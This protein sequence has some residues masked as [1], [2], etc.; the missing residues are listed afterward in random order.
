MPASRLIMIR[1]LTTLFWLL[2]IALTATPMVRAQGPLV[3][4]ATSGRWSEPSTWEN[5]RLPGAG[6]RV[7]VRSG[8]SVV[9]DARVESAIRSIHVA[10]TLDFD[11]DRDV[12]LTVGLIK[13]QSG[14]DTSETGLD[15]HEGMVEAG[16]G[17]GMERPALLVGTARRPISAGHTAV[18]RL[19][20]VNGLDPENCPAIVCQ[21]GRMEFHGA[22]VNPTWTKLAQTAETGSSVVELDRP[23]EGWRV[24]DRVIV[25]STRHQFRSDERLTPRVREAPQTEERTIL[26]VE[27]SRLTLDAPLEKSHSVRGN[28][29]GE[30]ALLSR[31]VVVES[32]NPEGVRGHTM[33]HRGSSGS[34]SFA[35]FRHLGKAGKLGKYS[36]HF[37]KVGDSMRGSSVVGASI[38]DSANRWITIHGTNHLV[39]QD[40]VGYRGLGHGFFL[41]D[42]TEVDNILDGNLAVQAIQ[43]SPLPGQ[44]L[45]YDRNEG[46]GFWWANSRN[47][48][49][50]NVAVE[51]DGYGFHLEAPPSNAVPAGLE[52]IRLQ[53]FL[54]FDANEAHS[55]RRYGVNLGGASE[56]GSSDR[57]DPVGPDSKHPLVIRG[58]RIW[59]SHWAFSPATPGLLVEGLELAHSEYGFWKPNFDRQAYHGVSL[60]QCGKRYANMIGQ[61][62]DPATFPEPLEPLDDRPPVSVITDVRPLGQDQLR[63]VGCSSDD[64]RIKAV[65]VNG[66]EVRPLVADFSRWELTLNPGHARPITL[67]AAAEDEAG[68]V[69]RTPHILTI[70][71]PAQEATPPGPKIHPRH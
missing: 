70:A 25:T 9:F 13:I 26:A 18:I 50:R 36:L 12:L 31:N 34:I 47:A 30:V 22:R 11:S 7:L 40:C 8:H 29:R 6:D 64:G 56:Q 62:P 3:R 39:V 48:F 38:W 14:D 71:S 42:G 37:H 24:G 54:R 15:A 51:C 17:A 21:G 28:F 68:N 19:A 53:P 60:Y 65:R 45:A 52:D 32:A 44:V 2:A 27:G 41:E 4:S 46:A 63:V 5:G 49:T 55:H 61:P 35:E 59:D 10:G 1:K 20:E 58:L 69:E 23:V 43:A 66:H 57:A 67:T 16:A 33:Y